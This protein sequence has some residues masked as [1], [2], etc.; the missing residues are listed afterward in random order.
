M[1]VCMFS[2]GSDL[3]LPVNI[4]GVIRK[5]L[6]DSEVDQ[7]EATSD[8]DEVGGL[9]ITVHDSVVMNMLCVDTSIH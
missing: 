6:R 5:R 8:E 3:R 4:G 7:F 9:E 2:Y 1:Y